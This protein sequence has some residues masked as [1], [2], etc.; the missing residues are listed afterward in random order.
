[1]ET[2]RSNAWLWPVLAILLAVGAVTLFAA[3]IT[4]YGGG[5]GMMGVGWGWGIAMM[6]VPLVVLLLVVLVLV[7]A[8]APREVPMGYVTPAP[9]P[10]PTS[11]A[12]EIL[13]ARY[14]RGEDYHRVLGDRLRRFADALPALLGPGETFRSVDTG[15]VL[16]KAWAERAGIGWTGKHTNLVSRE[17]GSWT[18]LGVLLTTAALPPDP[19]HGDFCGACDRCMRACPTGAIVAPYQLDARLCISYL[20]IELRGAIPRPLRPLLGNRVFGC[21]DCLAVCP[22][23]RFATEARDPALAPPRGLAFPDLVSLLRLGEGEYRERFRRTALHRAKRSGLRRNAAVALGNVG[24]PGAVPPLA[25]ALADPDPLVRGHAA[26]ALGAVGG[27]E[28]KEALAARARVENDSF[29][30]DEI[31]AAQAILRAFRSV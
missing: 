18:F 26:W 15:A 3:V 7:G 6:L 13:N 24:G 5:Y 28:A 2:G 25:E 21:D 9:P 16:E 31:V 30:A 11:S 29:V 27:T 12:L 23:N 8:L 20:T 22:W 17:L 4:P 19:P 10:M 14:A 1:M